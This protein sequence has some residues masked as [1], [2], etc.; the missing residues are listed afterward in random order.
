MSELQKK[1]TKVLTF[2]NE[3]KIRKEARDKEKERK[4]QDKEKESEKA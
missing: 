2:G 3:G 1:R 4:K